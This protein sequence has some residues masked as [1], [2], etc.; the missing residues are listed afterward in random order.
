MR[1]A[2]IAKLGVLTLGCGG[3]PP[4]ADAEAVS[5]ALDDWRPDGIGDTPW[6]SGLAAWQRAADRGEVRR[7]VLA[8]ADVSLP[9]EAD[10][11]W[12]VDLRKHEAWRTRVA[13]GSGSGMR[14][15]TTFSDEEGSHQTSLGLY[16][17][18]EIYSGKHGRSLRL[19]GLSASNASARQRAIVVHSADYV[20]DA[21]VAEHGRSGRSW[22]CPAVAP[23]VAPQV[24][25]ALTGG[26]ALWI[27]HPDV[28]VP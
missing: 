19:D 20:D 14:R 13:H 5:G 2:I 3:W 23:G 6:T 15:A 12:I 26:G 11:L 10:R 1:A 18:A 9:S 4:P 24:I 25:D 17:G 16:A 22:G 8:I 7:P 21:F 28:A 27:W